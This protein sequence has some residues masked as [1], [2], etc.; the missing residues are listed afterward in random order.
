M[1]SFKLGWKYFNPGWNI[2]ALENKKFRRLMKWKK[3][4]VNEKKFKE[5]N[6]NERRL[7]RKSFSDFLGRFRLDI[8]VRAFPHTFI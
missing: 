7:N 4:K 1:K 3:K 6:V 2:I 5:K 8:S